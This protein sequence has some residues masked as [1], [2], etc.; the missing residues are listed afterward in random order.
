MSSTPTGRSERRE[1]LARGLSWSVLD[2]AIFSASNFLPGVFL[3]RAVDPRSFSTFA[4]AST[5]VIFATGLG[6][7]LVGEPLLVRASAVQGNHRIV[8]SALLTAFWAGVLG[9]V[10]FAFAG[11]FFV[12]EV[13]RSS[14]FAAAVILPAVLVQ[15]AG[16]YALFALLRHH[17]AAANDALWLVIML[18]GFGL[19][20]LAG[21]VS[22]TVA[23]FVWGGAGW[24]AAILVFRQVSTSPW[25][26]RRAGL[27]RNLDLGSH[28]AVQYFVVSGAA[29]VALF[30][31]GWVADLEAIGAVRAAQLLFGP[32]NV[33]FL[34]VVV[35]LLPARR[36]RDVVRL[37]RDMWLASFAMSAL[38]ITCGIVLLSLPLSA[39]RALLGAT[40]DGA[41]ALVV[42][43][44][45][46]MLTLTASTG[47]TVGLTALEQVRTLSV[48]RLAFVPIFVVAPVAAGAL[49]G[50]SAF[51]LGL[52]V[53]GLMM[54]V[55]W[56][57]VFIAASRRP[58][59][60]LAERV[61]A[62]HP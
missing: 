27:S 21:A 61:D 30:L 33:I 5:A 43:Y 52:A 55:V 9:S 13:L 47:P 49:G 56:W 36:H 17:R 15:D 19:A 35:I 42:P 20:H 3:A 37:R 62:F 26:V 41:R 38:A 1:A 53:V 25:A 12:D 6:R 24:V 16:R 23:L 22:P 51:V 60:A 46:Y 54:A 28:F 39:G 59:P 32:M 50:S 40:W 31:L 18:A 4:V 29:H 45:L 58:A 48:V 2:Q 8:G 10:V 57:I 34:G 44:T 7:A 14:L 11:G